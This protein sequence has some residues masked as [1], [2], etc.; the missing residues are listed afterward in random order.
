MSSRILVAIASIFLIAS[1][2][3]RAQPPANI[4]DL[5]L[6]DWKPKSMLVVKET[7]VD[8]PAFPVF[9]VHNHLGTGKKFLTP[10]RV[11][12]YLAEMD[13]AGVDTVVNLDG[14]WDNDL[15]ETLDALDNAHPSRFLT[16]A[17]IN[18]NGLDDADWGQREAKRLEAGF[19]KG[20]KGLKFHKSFGLYFRHKDGTLLKVDDPKLDPIFEMCAKYHRPVLIHT[21]DPAAFFTPLD[22]NNER[23]HELNQHPDWLFYGKDYPTQ[24]EMLGQFIRLVARHPKT[25]FIGAH[26]DN[27][28]EDLA[29][30]SQWLDKYP[31][32]MCEFSARINELGRQPYT[33]RKFLLKYQDRVMF[34]TD[35]PCKRESYRVYYRFLETDDEYFDSTPSHHLQGFW[36]IYGVYLPK[37]VLEKIYHKNAE[38]ILNF[39]ERAPTGETGTVAP[40]TSP[41][42]APGPPITS[43]PIAPGPPIKGTAPSAAA[44]T[45]PSSSP[46]SGVPT[47]KVPA[48]E[49]FKITG[50]GSSPAWQ[51]TAWVP[52]HKR[53][54]GGPQLESRFKM[55]HSPTGVYV[56]FNGAD[57]KLT[58]TIKTDFANLWKEDVFEV[59]LWP[60]ERQTVYFEYEISP[61]N[62]ELAILVPNFD[63]RKLGWRPWHYEGPRKVRKATSVSG[64]EMKPGADITGWTA[65]VFVPYALLDPLGNVPPAPHTRWRANFYRADY[66]DGQTSEWDWSRVGPSFHEFKK[67]GVL[68]FE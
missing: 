68:E 63:G 10:A 50:D 40:I 61:L 39:G 4:R 28:V 47:L 62:H 27:N 33:A 25:T 64:G 53:P 20:A 26:C 52:L 51:K 8:K 55:L 60:D 59:F 37:D 6:K 54:G 43:P 49:D 7:K 56:L 17:Q 22:K 9:D 29:T 21:G 14:M 42:I 46:A 13:A 2:Q 19:I 67:F 66:D 12:H 15:Q 41:P 3:A 45:S 32:L 34:G 65:E 23:W 57:R 58:A 44:P 16:F 18:F 35:T 1:G 36:M 31:N 24:K 38:R 5:K 48:T 30:V 11:A